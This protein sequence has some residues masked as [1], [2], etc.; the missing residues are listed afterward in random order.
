MF[1][2]QVYSL[3]FEVRANNALPVPRTA[4]TLFNSVV[5][6]VLTRCQIELLA[7]VLSDPSPYV[8]PLASEKFR[9]DSTQASPVH[10][11]IAKVL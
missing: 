11:T 6:D 10:V 9:L 2:P 3:P 8:E 1:I 4:T 5:V 7:A